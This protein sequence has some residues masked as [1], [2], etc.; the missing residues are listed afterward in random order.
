MRKFGID[1]LVQVI[2]TAD[3]KNVDDEHNYVVLNLRNTL[4]DVYIS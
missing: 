2:L 1:N 4:S 3:A